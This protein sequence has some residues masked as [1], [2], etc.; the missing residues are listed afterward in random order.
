MKNRIQVQYRMI[1]TSPFHMGTGMPRGLIDRSVVR[2]GDDYLYIPGSTIKGILREKCE[3]LALNP[4]FGSE[5]LRQVKSPHSKDFHAFAQTQNIVD[6][7]FGSQFREGSLFFDDAVMEETSSDTL[8]KKFFQDKK[9]R[10]ERRIKTLQVEVR[11]RNSVSRRTGTTVEQA[12]FS[13]EY[14][15][16]SLAFSGEI[17]GTIEGIPI[18]GE[19]INYALVLFVA[20]LR[21][22]D[23]IGANKSVG[24]G[25]F[26]LRI[27][28]ENITVDEKDRPV[29]ELLEFLEYLQ[30]YDDALKETL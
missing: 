7:I 16:R 4:L 15:I 26:A 20:G 8:D 3:Q 2:D 9:P 12:L 18:A 6:R 28:D 30:L 29:N 11:A 13:S 22:F 14:G 25:K 5:Q 17:F 23:C 24:M 21:L 19:E 1:F 10:R 27:K